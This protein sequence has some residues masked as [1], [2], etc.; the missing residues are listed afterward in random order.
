MMSA[1]EEDQID[2]TTIENPGEGQIWPWN[3]Y[4]HDQCVMK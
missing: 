2:F 1:A 4:A 3:N